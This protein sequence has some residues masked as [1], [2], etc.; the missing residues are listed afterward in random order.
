MRAFE[1][2]NQL[3]ETP[4][5]VR[6]QI[7]QKVTK[8]QD[9]PDLI[10]VLKYA[11]QYAFKKDVNKLSTIKGYRDIVSNVILQAVGNVDA[12]EKE[13]RAFLKRLA[14]DGVIKEEL[15]L[16]PGA[17]H[18]M[19][20]IVDTK[21]L[22]IFQKI[23]LDLFEKIS[24]KIGEKGDVGKGEY[25]LA[26][27]S[28]RIERRGA[29]GDLTIAGAKV[30]LKAGESGRLG[31][32]GSQP[33]SGRFD[34][35]VNLLSRAKLISAEGP[36]DVR[37]MGFGLNMT[38][39]S[40]YF[41]NDPK[42]IRSALAIMLKMHYPSLD[43]KAM[44]K[45]VVKG[46]A[47]DAAELKRQMLSASYSVYQAAKEFDGVLLTDYGINRYLYINSPQTAAQAAPFLSVKWPSWTDTQSNCMKIQLYKK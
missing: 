6:S 29:P 12:P 5:E 39:F 31:P 16:T 44:A 34:E 1:L 43:T 10:N 45:A 3:L 20:Q 36:P 2:S 46:N 30:E 25:L 19:D 28:P 17:V 47:I 35:Y 38:A 18:S 41:G 14:S 11:N 8:I 9:E 23:K 32:A 7:V 27:L 24:G 26:I 13:V 33:I 40:Q 37:A 4:E 15:L 42:A 22:P 21:F